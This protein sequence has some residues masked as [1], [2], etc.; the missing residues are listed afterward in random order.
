V[1]PVVATDDVWNETNV[2]AFEKKLEALRNHYHIPSL[3]V[4]IVNEKNL[5]WKKGIWLFRYRKQK[6]AG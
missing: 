5:A 1:K 3:S 6:T 2:A 4:G